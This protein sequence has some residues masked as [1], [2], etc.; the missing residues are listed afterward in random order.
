MGWKKMIQRTSDFDTL[1]EEIA[2][3]RE[4]LAVDGFIF[5]GGKDLS[6]ARAWPMIGEDTRLQRKGVGG[7]IIALS[8][9]GTSLRYSSYTTC[10]ALLCRVWRIHARPVPMHSIDQIYPRLH[11][12]YGYTE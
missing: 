9:T 5:G 11:G 4:H 8:S 2:L 3:F 10:T 7:A 6:G 12:G 1:R